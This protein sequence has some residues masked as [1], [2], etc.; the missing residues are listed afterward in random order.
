ML[1]YI[2]I[3]CL[4]MLA[5]CTP[6]SELTTSYDLPSELSDCKVFIIAPKNNFL[7]PEIR[8]IRCPNSNTT[9]KYTSGKSH[10]NIT[11]TEANQ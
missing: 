6:T 9:T 5:G 7:A 10:F 11:V 3:G 8:V 4:F 1:K 2:S